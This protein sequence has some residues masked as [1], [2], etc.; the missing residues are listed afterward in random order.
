MPAPRPQPIPRTQEIT[1]LCKDWQPEPLV[2]EVPK[3]D[4]QQE[5]VITRWV[6][7][8]DGRCPHRQW[9]RACNAAT[10]GAATEEGV[11]ACHLPDLQEP[12]PRSK[13][14]CGHQLV[15]ACSAPCSNAPNRELW[16]P[17]QCCDWPTPLTPAA[18][19]TSTWWRMA[20]ARSTCCPT[21]SSTWPTRPRCWWVCWGGRVGRVLPQCQAGRRETVGSQST[22]HFRAERTAERRDAERPG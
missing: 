10:H 21:T 15:Q 11:A 14:G 20:S 8:R 16:Q 4:K 7:N 18:M 6:G 5:R 19:R 2:P 9:Q 3:D 17:R 1:Q 12:L 13:C 22:F